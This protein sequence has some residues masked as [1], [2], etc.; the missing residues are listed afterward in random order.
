MWAADGQVLKE[1]NVES[2]AVDGRSR[3]QQRGERV[4]VDRIRDISVD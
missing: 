3:K 2:N 1:T 4:E